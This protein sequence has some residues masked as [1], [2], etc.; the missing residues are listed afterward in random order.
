MLHVQI[1]L[2]LSALGIKLLEELGDELDT[3]FG[4]LLARENEVLLQRCNTSGL[5]LRAIENGLGKL[6]GKLI[7]CAVVK[8]LEQSTHLIAVRVHKLKAA[9]NTAGSDERGVKFLNVVCGEY[10][11][12]SIARNQAIQR[13]EHA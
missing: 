11:N 10:G 4:T 6:L 8:A 3:F 5:F 12:D 7:G 9:I 1:R 2:G 13:I